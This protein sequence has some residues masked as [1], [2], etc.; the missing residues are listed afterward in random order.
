MPFPMLELPDFTYLF[1]GMPRNEGT[2]FKAA[3]IRNLVKLG[4]VFIP[5]FGITFRDTVPD[6]KTGL[7]TAVFKF[8]DDSAG[9]SSIAS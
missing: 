3:L 1:I 6:N 8:F 7:K 5:C 4:T 9:K 2:V